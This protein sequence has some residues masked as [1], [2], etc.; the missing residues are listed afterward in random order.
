MIES[1]RT[2][3]ISVVTFFIDDDIFNLMDSL[4]K[5]LERCKDISV[6]IIF[7]ENGFNE[8]QQIH[9]QLEE[10]YSFC[11]VIIT[12]KNLGYGR[13]HNLAMTNDVDYH[14][15]LNPDII[16]DESSLE[17]A[18]Q[19]FNLHPNCGL[20]SPLARW[21]D[22]QRQFL[23]KRY[24]SVLTLLVRGFAPTWIKKFLK[25]KLDLYNMVDQIDDIN[26]YWNPPIVSGCFMFFRNSV[27]QELKGF[28]P[29]FF[30]YF[31]DTDLSYRAVQQTD[32]AY[33]PQVQ[34]IHHGGN[35]SKKGLK[36]IL[37]FSS[38][39]LK[40]FNKNGWRLF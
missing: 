30:L 16:L 7:I 8:K 13:A 29:D 1:A 22:G 21:E 27:L 18:L 32:V 24:P 5:A 2:I 40:F 10:N 11:S 34:V 35:A 12:G 15:I 14:L 6:Q 4:I 17:Q 38:S 39:M 36:H 37:M 31:E 26:V 20:L 33:V 28:D 25:H 23:C 19:F 9:F 3:R